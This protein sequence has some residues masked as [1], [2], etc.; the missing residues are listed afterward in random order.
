MN[1]SQL[2]CLQPPLMT[3][4]TSVNLIGVHWSWWCA[5]TCWLACNDMCLSYFQLDSVI[6]CTPIQLGLSWVNHG[7]IS[8]LTRCVYGDWHS[9]KIHPFIQ[10]EWHPWEFKLSCHSWIL[11]D[12]FIVLFIIHWLY[13]ASTSI[14]APFCQFYAYL[15]VFFVRLC[16]HFLDHCD[17]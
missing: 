15:S 4:L 6:H 7:L 11:H 17:K 14:A 1:W 12:Y 8:G 10:F 16:F 13:R 3:N 9:V 5:T 2:G